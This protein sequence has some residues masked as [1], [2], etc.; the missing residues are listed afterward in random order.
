M[1]CALELFLGRYCCFSSQRRCSS[2][3]TGRR[4]ATHSFPDKATFE[5][6]SRQAHLPE[7]LASFASKGFHERETVSLLVNSL[8]Y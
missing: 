8:T 1:K 7:T 2:V 4:D 3:F 6:P 5:I